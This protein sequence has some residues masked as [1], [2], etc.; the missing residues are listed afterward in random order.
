MPTW[1]LAIAIAGG[2]S[3]CGLLL[4]AGDPSAGPDA[5]ASSDAGA[6]AIPD[7]GAVTNDGGSD[8]GEIDAGGER[9]RP[10][11][12]TI[13]LLARF[14]F[15]GD[16]E[17]ALGGPPGTFVG[18][19]ATAEPFVDGPIGCGRAITFPIRSDGVVSY[20]EIA[21]RE[22]WNSVQSVQL[23][24]MPPTDVGMRVLGIISRDE[25]FRAAPGHTTLVLAGNGRLSI[26]VQDPAT[27]VDLVLCS[28]EPLVAGRWYD[29]GIN[30]GPEGPVELFVDRQP[31]LNDRSPG[32]SGTCGARAGDAI[33]AGPNEL[34]WGV[35]ASLHQIGDPVVDAPVL[36]LGDGA[37]DDLRFGAERLPY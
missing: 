21:H 12:D 22:E 25:A 24:L 18:L 6:D 13:A 14:S 34:P 8:A 2:A 32:W 36:P 3:G 26:R 29:V 17:D 10:S 37:I 23:W 28:P 33:P 31:S 20:V 15:D 5:G 4:G 9:C 7:A 35:G 27:D 16:L 1:L 11:D 19:A 30:Y